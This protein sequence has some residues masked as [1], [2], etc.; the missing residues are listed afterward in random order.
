MTPK[1]LKEIRLKY[2][3]SQEAAGALIYVSQQA[4]AS[5]E[6]GTRNIPE[7]KEEIFLQRVKKMKELK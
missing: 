1:K 7:L 2:G 6:N 4:W 3:L 5:Y